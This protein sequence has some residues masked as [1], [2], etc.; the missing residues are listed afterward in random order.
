MTAPRLNHPNPTAP[1]H[2]PAS[3]HPPDTAT[4]RST[5]AAKTGRLD[6]ALWAVTGLSVAALAAVAGAISFDHM[7]ELAKDHGQIAWRANAFPVSVDGLELV[8]SLYILA[9]HRKGRPIGWLPWAALVVGTA[10]SLSAN[11]AM[12]G[13]DPVSKVLSGWPALCMLVAI[14][15]LFGMIDQPD[16]T[17]QPPAVP[18][19]QPAVPDDHRTVP[20][21]RDVPDTMGNDHRTAVVTATVL[22][23]NHPQAVPGQ[24]ALPAGICRHDCRDSR[25]RGLAVPGDRAAPVDIRAVADLIPAARSVRAALVKDGR[26]FTRDALANALRDDGHE[27]S[28]ARASLVLKILK[29]EDVTDPER[30]GSRGSFTSSGQTVNS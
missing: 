28:N 22:G 12:G 21:V 13:K 18:N 11:A 23:V 20:D 24:R 10:A 16:P 15:L 9:K 5:H 4:H 17:T 30:L 3:Q 19:D 8:A 1:N 6:S 29:A 14:K 27:V 25:G 7:K 26:S 2:R